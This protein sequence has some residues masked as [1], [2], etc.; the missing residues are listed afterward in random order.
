MEKKSLVKINRD[1]SNNFDFGGSRSNVSPGVAAR[2]S[3]V[4][5]AIHPETKVNVGGAP[6]S[7]SGPRNNF[8]KPSF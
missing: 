1:P 4:N 7:K 2:V 6:A 5:S 3:R 8:F